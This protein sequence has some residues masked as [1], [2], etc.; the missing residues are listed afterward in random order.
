[1]SNVSDGGTRHLALVFFDILL[2]DGV[3][4]LSSPYSE[5]RAIL[6]QTVKVIPGYSMLAER[7][8][9][10]MW[11]ADALA[12]L[13]S[14]FAGLIADHQEGAV[15]KAD[16]AQY[17]EKRSP[18]VKVPFFHSHLRVLEYSRIICACS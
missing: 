9:I 15:L 14:I 7:E 3:S 18:W 2:L 16:G 12:T 1:M 10:D 5:R 13:K 4:L 8:C 6:E 11:R 17:G